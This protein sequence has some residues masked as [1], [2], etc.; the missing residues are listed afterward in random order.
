M[1]VAEFVYNSPPIRVVFG[2]GTIGKVADE[3]SRLGMRRALVLSTPEQRADA[4]RVLRLL[5]DRGRGVFAGARM[6][7]PLEVTQEAM[8]T[9]GRDG[10]DGT[11][12]LGGGSTT[13]LGKAIAWRTDLPQIVIPTTYAG[14]EMTDLLGETAGGE[15]KTRRD[16][17]IRPETVVY[18]VELTLGL[19]PKLSVTSAL[20]A[21]AHA[22][23]GLY[24]KDGNPVLSLMA[25]EG[26]RALGAALPA[27]ARD[28]RNRDARGDALYGAWLCG[29]VLGSSSI[30]IHHKLCHVLG[31]TFD[32]PHAETH[33][34]ILPHAIAYNA[35]A[36]PEA[37][38]R[39]ARALGVKNAAAGLFDMAKAAGAPT[40][41]GAIGMPEAGLDQA[42]D[43]AVADPYWNP[44]PLERDA[45]RALLDDA[46]R[47]RRPKAASS[48]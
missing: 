1:A 6:H 34:I 32:L 28:P 20:N 21:M 2:F 11:V 13:G 15:K 25:E 48:E 26:I 5:G 8:A 39:V 3:A 47:G 40:A 10:I 46:W 43:L 29:I 12:A 36:A 7:T 41:L 18:D 35:A 19:P 30:A 38:G 31:G 42:A 9:V 24:A 4:E 45:I 23:E 17:K 44:R 16:P 14:S 33:A 22:V 27:F 37:I